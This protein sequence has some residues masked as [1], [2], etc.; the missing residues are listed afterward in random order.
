MAALKD[1]RKMIVIA[2]T[3]QENIVEI[4]TQINAE[5]VFLESSNYISY[6]EYISKD[7]YLIKLDW[8]FIVDSR[9]VIAT[10]DG[11][12]I[13]D[14]LPDNS[15]LNHYLT[16]GGHLEKLNGVFSFL[17]CYFTNNYFHWTTQVLPSF[18]LMNESGI[19]SSSTILLPKSLNQFQLSSLNCLD[20]S[21]YNYKV[22]EPY[23]IYNIES[24][25]YSTFSGFWKV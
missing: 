11:S 17:P 9:G 21:K 12:L 10:S 20:L 6:K 16:S 4:I 2:C 25:F 24:L 18:L 15:T 19:S 1:F 13:E 8:G 5:Q 14:T 23:T 3:I 22:L 7:N